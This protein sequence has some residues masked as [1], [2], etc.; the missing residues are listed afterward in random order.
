MSLKGHLSKML[1]S[2]YHGLHTPPEHLNLKLKGR[3]EMHCA[4]PGD[5]HCLSFARNQSHFPKV[6]QLTNSVD[7]TIYELCNCYSI[8]WRW[9]HSNQVE[10]SSLPHSLFSSIEKGSGVCRGNNSGPKKLPK[11]TPDTTL[12]RLL[13]QPSSTTYCDRLERNCVKTDSTDPPMVT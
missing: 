6:K 10:S 7:I 11:G 4:W 8:K 9:H 1:H 12:T 3:L 2:Q 5:Y 13:W